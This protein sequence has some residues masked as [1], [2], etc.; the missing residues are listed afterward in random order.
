MSKELGGGYSIL[1]ISAS[2]LTCHAL[3]STFQ[4]PTCGLDVNECAQFAG[5]DLGCQNGASCVNT[6]GGYNCICANGSRHSKDLPNS[7]CKTPISKFNLGYQGLHCT[8]Q[9]LN[10]ANG[11]AELCGNGVCIQQGATYSCI[12]NQG[13]TTGGGT[14]KACNVDVNEC[15]EHKPHC[16]KDPLVECVNLPG[17]FRCGSCPPGYSGNGYY[18]ADINECDYNNGGCSMAP[19]V[20]CI[21]T[22]VT[23]A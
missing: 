2:F 3:W 4:G 14:S 12:C 7:K 16:S 18:C 23:Y 9:N 10:C 11:G 15:L 22:R 5:T 17:S 20:Q 13:W 8:S 1:F 19:Y 21:N 6:Q